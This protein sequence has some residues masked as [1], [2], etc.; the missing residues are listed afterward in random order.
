VVRGDFQ[1]TKNACI[2][3]A[4]HSFIYSSTE[5]PSRS[6]IAGRILT[7]DQDEMLLVALH[8]F[9]SSFLFLLS[10]PQFHKRYNMRIL[11]ISN[12]ATD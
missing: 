7:H 2:H 4:Q 5:V 1:H 8:F 11:G 6:N 12:F 10:F 3:E 9:L